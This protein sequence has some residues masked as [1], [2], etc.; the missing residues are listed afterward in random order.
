MEIMQ[1]YVLGSHGKMGLFSLTK[2]V[3]GENIHIFSTYPCEA[4]RFY[5]LENCR[6]RCTIEKHEN[7]KQKEATRKNGELDMAQ[8][9]AIPTK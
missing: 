3:E 7:Q 1:L 6:S 2:N 5:S 9:G 8:T 4:S